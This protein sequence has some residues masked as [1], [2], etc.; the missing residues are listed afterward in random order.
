MQIHAGS[1]NIQVDS[2][3]HSGYTS[4]YPHTYRTYAESDLMK[5]AVKLI[6]VKKAVELKPSNDQISYTTTAAAPSPALQPASMVSDTYWLAVAFLFFAYIIGLYYRKMRG[7]AKSGGKAWL[8]AAMAILGIVCVRYWA[9]PE[10]KIYSLN[11][12]EPP[13]KNAAIA[14]YQDP[15]AATEVILRG[16]IANGLLG[17]SIDVH[18]LASI[19]NEVAFPFQAT[20]FTPGMKYAQHTYGRD[21][22]G[23]EFLLKQLDSGRYEIASAGPDGIMGTKDDILL[24]TLSQKESWEY[25]IGGVFARIAKGQNAIFI[26]R[27]DDSNFVFA[28]AKDAQTQTGTGIFD[29]LGLDELGIDESWLDFQN[30]SAS[31]PPFIAMLLDKLKPEQAK[32][33]SNDLF[34]VQFER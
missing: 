8:F 6:D 30:P 18:N 7:I 4:A 12:L 17:I 9:W 2:F 22:W 21:G 3:L 5:R 29:L 10:Y 31:D 27:V 28:H 26:H 20:Q 16:L 1:L 32:S 11:H 15:Q 13:W 34:F 19:Q 33:T 23:R 14:E 24:V 25:R